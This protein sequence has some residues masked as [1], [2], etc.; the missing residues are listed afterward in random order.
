[1]S[2]APPSASSSLGRE[3]DEVFEQESLQ[4]TAASKQPSDGYEWKKYGQKPIKNISKI[5]SYYKCRNKNCRVKKRVE[6]PHGDPS[7]LQITYDG[8]QH[9][10]RPP[11]SDL[12]PCADHLQRASSLQYELGNQVFGTRSNNT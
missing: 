5:R 11:P 6:W 9:N 7:N 8:N 4:L 2:A 10:H 12:L 3:D 1:M